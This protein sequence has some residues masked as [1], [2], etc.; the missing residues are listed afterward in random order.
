[1]K[2]SRQGLNRQRGAAAVE[3]ALVLPILIL[4]LVFTMFFARYFWHYSVAYKA[5]FDSAR[6]LSTISEQEMRE[7]ALARAAE[8]ITNEIILTEIAELRPR[9]SVRPMVTILCGQV[10]CRG[11]G[12]LP[13]PQ[14]V[15]VSINMDMHDDIFG[16]DLGR[17]GI[18]ISVRTEVRYVGN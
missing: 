12:G 3:L 4:L 9:G 5:A 14:T 15:S 2:S 11:I 1:M 6:Y 13:L 18:P 17:Y 7:G 16:L 8:N 10:L